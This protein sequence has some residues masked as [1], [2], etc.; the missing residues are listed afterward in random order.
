[1]KAL[2]G[3]LAGLSVLALVACS[4]EHPPETKAPAFVWPASL[5]IVGDGFPA[6]GDIC[7]RVGETPAT[8]HFLDHSA[9]LVGCPGAASS[10]ASQALLSHGDARVVGEHDGVTLISVTGAPSA[11]SAPPSQSGPV[12][13]HGTVT[14]HDV[15]THD[16]SARQG[17]T[18]NITLARQ[19]TVYFNV[20]PPGGGPA[21][22]IFVGSRDSV[23]DFF[24]GVAPATGQYSIIVYLMGND[25]DS[26][27]RR[28]YTL[29][30]AAE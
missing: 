16:F 24:S 18:I 5:R 21:D 30:V 27:A 25:R 26:G 12:E 14:G 9:I 11:Q 4:S 3:A 29:R 10:A 13:F 22:A 23:G 20:L 1:M 15:T 8:S 28:P 19:G 6:P 2:I 17:Q 7:R